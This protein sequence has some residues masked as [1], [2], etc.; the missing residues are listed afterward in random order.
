M[1]VKLI[2]DGF[3]TVTPYIVVEGA[4][5]V[6]EFLKKGFDAEEIKCAKDPDGKIMCAEIRIGDSMIML[7]EPHESLAP[8][9]GSLYLYVKDTDAAYR[10]AIAAG[11]TSLMEPADMFY[12]DR[13]A[14]VKDSAGNMWWIATHIEDVSAEEM[15]RREE[16]FLRSRK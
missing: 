12:G 9:P 5:K 2:P 14:G 11:G 7:G 16:E 8:M 1:P 10:K 6:I 15:K 4:S 13:N 3:R